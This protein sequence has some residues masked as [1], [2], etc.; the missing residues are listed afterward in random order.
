MSKSSALARFNEVRLIMRVYAVIFLLFGI[1]SI[2]LV[3]WNNYGLSDGGSQVIESLAA[4]STPQPTPDPTTSLVA[5][6]I[7]IVFVGDMMFD[8]YIRTK[9]EE[10]SYQFLLEQVEPLFET[11]DLVVGNLEAPITDFDSVSQKTATTSAT[12]YTFTS[13]PEIA[14]VLSKYPF[15]ANLGNNHIAN[16]R[17]EGIDQTEEYLSAAQIPYFGQTGHGSPT[18]TIA[19]LDGLK[20]ALINYNQ[21]VTDSERQTMSDL[22]LLADSTDLQIV[23]THWGIEYE[24]EARPVISTLAH[25]FVDAGADMIIGSHPHVIQNYELYKDVSIYYSLGNFVFD[26]YFS[27][28]VRTGL[29]VIAEIEPKT[30]TI[31]TST[32]KVRLET[33]GQ[34]TLLAN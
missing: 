5:Q 17:A 15:V 33:T 1:A 8:R 12:H 26:Q 10:Q 2:A 32:R 34:T 6:S 4:T 27:T 21:F 19:E 11:T 23:Y 13:D 28:E 25:Q 9:A 16:F 3:A 24:P 22:Q 30:M 29:V 20:I 18:Y 31:S 14:T 7:K